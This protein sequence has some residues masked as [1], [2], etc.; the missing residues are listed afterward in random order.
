[1]QSKPAPQPFAPSHQDIPPAESLTDP[2]ALAALMSHTAPVQDRLEAQRAS[3]N[4]AVREAGYEGAGGHQA[5]DEAGVDVQDWGRG[6]VDEQG[7]L[8]DGEEAAAPATPGFFVPVDQ[9]EFGETSI[10]L[11]PSMHRP[12]VPPGGQPLQ[13]RDFGGLQ[14]REE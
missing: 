13:Q 2:S 11:D 5:V 14:S 10:P 9:P 7:L 12:S 6:R 3:P 8:P 1:M 4:P